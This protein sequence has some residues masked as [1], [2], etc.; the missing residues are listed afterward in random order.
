M[1]GSVFSTGWPNIAKKIQ[2]RLLRTLVLTAWFFSAGAASMAQQAPDT[3]QK[4]MPGR[5][6]SLEQQKNPMSS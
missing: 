2:M 4:I 6:N 5:A 1:N 3:T